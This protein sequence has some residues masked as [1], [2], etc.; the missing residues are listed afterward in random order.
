M[1]DVDVLSPFAHSIGT[2]TAFA[3]KGFGGLMVYAGKC[4]NF[5]EKFF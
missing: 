4:A 5:P 2:D 1:K 3:D